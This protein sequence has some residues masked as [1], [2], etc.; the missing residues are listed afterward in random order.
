MPHTTLSIERESNEGFFKAMSGDPLAKE[1]SHKNL[2]GQGIGFPLLPLKFARL[3]GASQLEKLTF[4]N[5]LIFL[6]I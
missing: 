1:S 5:F 2:C 6:Y 4:F 3:S